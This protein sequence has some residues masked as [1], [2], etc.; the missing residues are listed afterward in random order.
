[1]KDIEFYF[2]FLSPYS[3]LAW[4]WVRQNTD[5]YNFSF[6]P[7]PLASLIRSY[8]T[9]GPAEIEPKRNYLFKHCLRYA[10]LNKIPFSPPQNL[11]FNSLYALR[12]ALEE[13]AGA[14]QF[15]VIDAIYMNGWGKGHDI[16]DEKFLVKILLQE[17]IDGNKLLDNVGSKEIRNALKFNLNRAL[18]KNIFGLPTFIVENELFWGNDSIEH[19]KLFLGEM[20]PLDKHKYKI[21]LEKEFTTF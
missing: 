20:D 11:P 13:N 12:M 10:E 1:M 8:E 21:F 6:Y 14:D 16:G 4:S 9:K 15:K 2:D 17:G 19:L 7:V 5:K 18:G 3:Y